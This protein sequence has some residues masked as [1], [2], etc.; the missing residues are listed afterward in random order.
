MKTLSAKNKLAPSE[1]VAPAEAQQFV[2][3]DGVFTTGGGEKNTILQPGHDFD[4]ITAPKPVGYFVEGTAGS[5]TLYGSALND[6][7][8]GGFGNDTL[9]GRD[10]NDRLYGEEGNDT[11]EGGF[12][13]D[14]LDGG[15]GQDT[16]SYRQSSHNVT[17]DL[18]YNQGFL[19]DAEGDV[20]VSIE[21]VIGS[22]GHDRIFGNAGANV[23]NGGAGND[24][25]V[26]GAGQ[27]TIIGGAGQDI[28][29]GDEA[30]IVDADL[31]VFTR[32]SGLDTITDFQQGVDKIDLRAFGLGADAFGKGGLAWGTFNKETGELTS[33]RAL[34]E[35]DRLFFDMDTGILWECEYTFV[36]LGGWNEPGTLG[37]DDFQLLKLL[38]PIA[39]IDPHV[40]GRLTADDIFVI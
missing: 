3:T 12:G 5:D 11:L 14:I 31:F 27:D 15:A 26:G 35:G 7:M 30:G 16:V 33:A 18:R 8:F 40:A 32:G 25:I 37:Q 36:E 23:L 29:T 34:D 10:G 22:N 2:I 20:Y 6:D 39:Q 24:Q 21:N 1:T 9:Y 19:G 28:L 17:V 13:A 4:G 38:N